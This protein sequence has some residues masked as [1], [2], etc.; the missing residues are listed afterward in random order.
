MAVRY[1]VIL[2]KKTLVQAMFAGK[3]YTDWYVAQSR[4]LFGWKKLGRVPDARR[5]GGGVQP[6]CR[7]GS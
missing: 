6:A 7:V 1:R 4:W 3:L 2:Q 5:G